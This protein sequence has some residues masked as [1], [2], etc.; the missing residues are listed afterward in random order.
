MHTCRALVLYG[1]EW[2]TDVRLHQ[3][4]VAFVDQ[5]M[6]RRFLIG[7]AGGA[8]LAGRLFNRSAQP[9]D[10]ASLREYAERAA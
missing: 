4:G 3:S 10:R 1:R 7:T 8:D 9:F 6:M 2:T 5:L